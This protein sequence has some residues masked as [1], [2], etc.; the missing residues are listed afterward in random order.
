MEVNG[1]LRV[2]MPVYAVADWGGLQE[3]YSLLVEGLLE[4][5]VTV[6]AATSPGI[7]ADRLEHHGA[8]VYRLDWSKNAASLADGLAQVACDIVLTQPFAS[9]ELGLEFAQRRSI[10]VISMFHGSAHDQVYWW[11]EYVERFIV[12]APALADM[13]TGYAKIDP[14]KIVCI[15]NGV[16]DIEFAGP[17]PTL[18]ERVAEGTGHIAIAARLA[19]EKMAQAAV[20]VSVAQVCAAARPDLRWVIDVYGDGPMRSDFEAELIKG[21]SGSVDIEHVMHGWVDPED[22][23]HAVRGAVVSVMAG[24][25]AVH[26][27][28]A[29]S[30]VVAV[31]AEHYLGLVDPA[32]LEQALNSNFG[33]YRLSGSVEARDHSS[34]EAL[35]QGSKEYDAFVRNMRD[36][37]YATRRQSGVTAAV[38]ALMTEVLGVSSGSAG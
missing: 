26:A 28:A 19:R 31:G 20:A 36:E 15:P 12:T 17:C 5:G 9:R 22:V 37:L 10:P 7:L 29:G 27:V 3:N 13:L 33:D 35:V 25:G 38:A 6:I 30:L 23:P 32:G 21:L 24:R 2:F 18:V 16:P 14:E 4:M 34:L 11:G 8:E 1:P